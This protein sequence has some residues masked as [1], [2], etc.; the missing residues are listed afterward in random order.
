MAQELKVAELKLAPE[1]RD[2]LIQCIADSYEALRLIPGVDANGPALVW[3]AEHILH[4][5][6]RAQR[7]G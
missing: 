6:R 5:H 1:E 4:A 3:L 2:V 7:P